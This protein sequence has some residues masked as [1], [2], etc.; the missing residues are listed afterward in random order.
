M[1]ARITVELR[2]RPMQLAVPHSAVL[3][4]G[5]RSFVF[6]EQEDRVFARR[7]VLLGN[8]DDTSIAV[9]QGLAEGERIAVG[10]VS[11]LQSGFAALR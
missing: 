1:L 5:L 8:R 3:R 4:E 11:G 7:P 6:V 9:L 10:G 2:K